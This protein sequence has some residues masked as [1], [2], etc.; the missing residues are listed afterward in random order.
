[1]KTTISGAARGLCVA[2]MLAL[3][4]PLAAFAQA[5]APA[6][7]QQPPTREQVERRLAS[8]GLLFGQSS[9]VK[10]IEASSNLDAKIQLNKA[11]ELLAQAKATLDTGGVEAADKLLQA[12]QRTMI[13]AV[14]MASA[15]QVHARKDR[16]DYDARR[17]STRAL[18]DAGQR[19]STEKG[20]G[21]RNAEVM[22]RIEATIAEADKMVA[23]NKLA[24]GRVLLDQAYGAARA[25]VQGM[26]G[27]ETLVRS[28]N[29]ANKEEEFHYEIDRNE[30]HR[31]L[32]TLLL[33]DRRGGS[34]DTLVERALEASTRLRKQAD[35]QAQRREFDAG[36]KS[37]EDSTRELQRAIR[38]A[39]VYIPG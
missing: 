18:L 7:S 10:Q 21:P 22:K 35:E 3:I 2:L 17:E 25:A 12:A 26:R 36:V 39:G 30:T 38:A 28:L 27:G 8:L 13:E 6:G 15:D 34:V 16:A 19:I 31:M 1:V 14:R 23:A 29:F 32:I 33:Q 9:G 24:E 5:S 4:A 20:A 11:R 37:L